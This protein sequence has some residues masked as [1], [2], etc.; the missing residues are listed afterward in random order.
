[1]VMVLVSSVRLFLLG[2]LRRSNQSFSAFFPIWS[3]LASRLTAWGRV[4][5][6][7][8]GRPKSFLHLVPLSYCARS[9]NKAYSLC[10]AGTGSPRVTCLQAERLAM[11]FL[12]PKGCPQSAAPSASA[13]GQVWK[14]STHRCLYAYPDPPQA[15]WLCWFHL[16]M[17][18]A[19]Q[20]TGH[21]QILIWTSWEARA[22]AATCPHV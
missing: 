16:L 10:I 2:Q 13:L 1:M 17:A 19:R 21:H 12:G 15:S 9:P 5:E 14:D 20:R 18:S 3:S 4:S 22:D 6:R 7:S 11:A 8:R